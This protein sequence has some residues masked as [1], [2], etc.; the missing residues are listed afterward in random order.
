[1]VCPSRNP[2]DFEVWQETEKIFFFLSHGQFQN[3]SIR[4]ETDQENILP[5][6]TVYALASAPPGTH[7]AFPEAMVF[8]PKEYKQPIS[9]HSSNKINAQTN[10]IDRHISSI[11]L[12]YVFSVQNSLHARIYFCLY[13]PII[14]TVIGKKYFINMQ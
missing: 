10:T 14:L 3:L 1:M 2:I 13:K 8:I 7:M 11:P 9:I 5:S 4:S 6:V 12:I